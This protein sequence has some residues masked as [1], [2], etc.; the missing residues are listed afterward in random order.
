MTI[1]TARRASLEFVCVFGQDG[2]LEAQIRGSR[3]GWAMRLIS[4]GALVRLLRLKEAVD[5]PAIVQQIHRILIPQE[6]TRL[7]S[8][9]DLVFLAAEDSTQNEEL[10]IGEEETTTPKPK[11]VPVAFR[12]ACIARVE[13]ALGL[14]LVKR[15]RACYSSP[16]ES[17]IVIC[18]VSKEHSAAANRLVY[19][20]TFHSHQRASLKASEH[21]YLAL[22]CG[23]LKKLLLIPFE[24]LEPWLDG[25]GRTQRNDRMSWHLRINVEGSE[26]KL[27]RKKGFDDIPVS[28]FLV[29]S[30]NVT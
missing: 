17:V 13:K 4:A 3:V 9:V 28:R 21:S 29:P 20:F 16:D 14:T 25:L 2:D 15:T 8:I 11:F 24:T 7:D 12:N 10:V 23:S 6:F 19:W 22:G 26:L 27:N 30:G 1:E 18:T 5:D